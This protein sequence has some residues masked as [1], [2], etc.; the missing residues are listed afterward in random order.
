MNNIERVLTV[1]IIILN[2]DDVLLVEHGEAAGH[3]TGSFGSPG[4]RVDPGETTLQA[5]VREVKEET[6]LDVEEDHLIELPNKYEADLARKDGSILSVHHTMFATRKFT[7]SLK[8]T[9]ETT[10]EW[11]SIDKLHGMELLPNTEDMV[12][13]AKENL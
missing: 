4:G 12:K 2:N 3:L 6:G 9:D 11:I 8:G 7:G 5:A 10:P 1:G 13:Q